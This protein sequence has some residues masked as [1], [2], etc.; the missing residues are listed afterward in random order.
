[1]KI[2]DLVLILSNLFNNRGS[3][4]IIDSISKNNRTTYYAIHCPFSS[5]KKQWYIKTE[6]KLIPHTPLS[7]LLYKSED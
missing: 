1:M 5:I 7:K 3:I 6:L 4:G 2:G